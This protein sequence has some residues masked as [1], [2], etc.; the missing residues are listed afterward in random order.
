VKNIEKDIQLFDIYSCFPVAVQVACKE[1]GVNPKRGA[2]TVTGGLPY[3]GGPGSNYVTHSVA[4]M[5][6]RLRALPRQARGLVTA[7]GG[8]LTKH[9]LGVYANFPDKA[10]LAGTWHRDDPKACQ[11]EVD[12]IPRKEVAE[13][14]EGIG[15]IESY[16]VRF[17]KKGP[18]LG[19]V[20]G[21]MVDGKE[22]GRR[23]V[24]NLPAGDTK[25]L[26]NFVE[27]DP[28]GA[29]GLVSTKGAKSTFRLQEPSKL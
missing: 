3:H 26:R 25:V 28:V 2:L 15:V 9:S 14:P 16:G 17:G 6:E 23:F 24:A 18:E 7:N 29:R 5:V 22:A 21:H 1:L 19:T 8:Y 13:A 10:A 20:V 12:A 11:A 4:A 27:G